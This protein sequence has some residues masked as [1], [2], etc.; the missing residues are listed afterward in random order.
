MG[1]ATRAEIASTVRSITEEGYGRLVLDRLARLACRTVGAEQAGILVSD[2]RDPRATLLVAAE[3]FDE[4]FIGGRFG[5]DEGVVGRVLSSSR[6]RSFS[7]PGE[8]PF[9]CDPGLG[10]GAC[11]GAAAPIEWDGAVQGVLVALSP[12]QAARPFS[13]QELGVLRA[14]A[15]VAGAA[16]GHA[17]RRDHTEETVRA[18][19]EALAAAL[20]LRDRV[21]GRHVHEVVELALEVGDRLGLEPA[22]MVELEFA[23]RLHDVGKIA[24]P[25]AIL[26][27]PGPLSRREWDAMRRHPELGAGMLAHIPGL[28]AVAII[29]RFHHERYDGG[30]YPDGLRGE[31]IPL[32]SRIVSV[33][34]AYNAMVADRPYRFGRGHGAALH[35]LDVNAGTQFDPEVVEAFCVSAGR[36][37]AG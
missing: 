29:V 33:C 26:R 9:A 21:T 8:L 27:H 28:E 20:E 24:I 25:D 13:G 10:G 31:C 11:S 4:E 18:R 1:Q 34:D 6:A 2:R 30:G 37:L 23:A 17:Q 32:A 12:S 3:G 35:E 14:V 5:A 36:S 19:V 15:E 16:L 22:A 7:D